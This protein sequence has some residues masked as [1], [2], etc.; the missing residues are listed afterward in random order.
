MRRA[1]LR[2]PVSKQAKLR[3]KIAQIVDFKSLEK[4]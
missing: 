3:K 1:T 2:Q 4:Q